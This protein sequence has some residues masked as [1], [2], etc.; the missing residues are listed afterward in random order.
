[1]TDLVERADRNGEGDLV[2]EKP[3]SRL[4]GD[5]EVNVTKLLRPGESVTA[6][7][8]ILVTEAEIAH[9]DPDRLDNPHRPASATVAETVVDRLPDGVDP[10]WDV[11]DRT[12]VDYP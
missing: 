1:M 3:G 11:V 10:A 5:S 7:V 12:E 2:Y 8:D 9:E 4:G 6:N